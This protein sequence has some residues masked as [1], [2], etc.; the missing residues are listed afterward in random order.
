MGRPD[1]VAREARQQPEDEV[2]EHD[3]RDPPE[4][5]GPGGR[6]PGRRRRR[7]R[8]AAGEPPSR[9]S[10]RGSAPSGLVAASMA[11][12]RCEES[13][14]NARISVPMH[15]SSTSHESDRASSSESSVRTGSYS[16]VISTNAR[17]T[18]PSQSRSGPRSQR[19][20]RRATEH[21][22]D[23]RRRIIA[24]TNVARRPGSWR[25]AGHGARE[26]SR[27]ALTTSPAAAIQLLMP[28][29]SCPLG[30]VQ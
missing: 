9:A 10:P 22:V 30:P 13:G 4:R 11:S 14:K 16:G 6:Q 8:H 18:R 2:D 7:R 15:S 27:P 24:W 5:L 23:H 17:G 26:L 21:G 1:E 19:L 28:P 25:P 12:G 20:R 29:R 3:R